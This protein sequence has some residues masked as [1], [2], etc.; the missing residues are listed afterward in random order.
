MGEK[1]EFDVTKN[2]NKSLEKTRNKKHERIVQNTKM[3]KE[4]LQFKENQG[5]AGNLGPES[6][7]GF[8]EDIEDDREL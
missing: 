1:F 4:N 7:Y 5:N 6:D 2:V 8:D 3:C